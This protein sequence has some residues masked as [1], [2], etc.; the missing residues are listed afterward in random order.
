MEALMKSLQTQQVRW[1]GSG[2]CRTFSLPSDCGSV[3][4]TTGD[5]PFSN[6]EGMGRY[7]V[8]GDGAG[9]F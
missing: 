2:R 8:V 4:R 7:I 3:V 1:G 9:Q 6:V 5:S